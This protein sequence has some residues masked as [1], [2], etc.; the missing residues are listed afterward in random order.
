MSENKN[1]F[2][3]LDASDVEQGVTEIESCCMNCFKNV[4]KQQ[5]ILISQK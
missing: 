5:L 1:I 2:R 4:S 3:D